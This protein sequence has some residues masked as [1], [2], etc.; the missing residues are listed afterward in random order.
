M[1][2]F[3]TLKNE[4]HGPNKQLGLIYLFEITILIFKIKNFLYLSHK[5]QLLQRNLASIAGS[6]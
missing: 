5:V 1:E 2:L 6:K 4:K 3:T